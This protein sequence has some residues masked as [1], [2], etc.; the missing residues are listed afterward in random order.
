MSHNWIDL[1]ECAVGANLFAWSFRPVFAMRMRMNSHLQT[2][3]TNCELRDK[4]RADF[5]NRRLL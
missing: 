4:F 3:I 5:Q 2:D 1:A